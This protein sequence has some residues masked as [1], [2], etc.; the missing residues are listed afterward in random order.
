VSPRFLNWKRTAPALAALLVL[1]AAGCTRRPEPSST[2][3]DLPPHLPDH[4]VTAWKAAGVEIGWV[5]V[6]RKD[7]S[8]WFRVLDDGKP[9]YLPAFQISH[10]REGLVT[11]LPDP[12]A[13]FGLFLDS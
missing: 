12:G 6:N 10:W 8:I 2:K 1:T 13:A 4:I 7:G 3:P 9:G 11:A 5:S